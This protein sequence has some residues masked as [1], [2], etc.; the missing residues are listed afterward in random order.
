MTALILTATKKITRV[1]RERQSLQKSRGQ[2]IYMLSQE[3]HDGDNGHL[4]CVVVSASFQP[5][6]GSRG[7]E[8][9]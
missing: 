7:A 5:S 6:G 9:P 8:A 3:L 4:A 2:K 1:C